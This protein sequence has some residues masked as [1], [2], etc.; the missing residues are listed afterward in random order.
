[1]VTNVQTSI[2]TY[3]FEKCIIQYTKKIPHENNLNL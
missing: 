2:F 3:F 1:M